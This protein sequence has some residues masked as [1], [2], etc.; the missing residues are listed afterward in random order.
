[1]ITPRAAAAA[2]SPCRVCAAVELAERDVPA[3][4]Q[5]EEQGHRRVVRR[6][7]RLR[8]HAT[9]EL[10]VKRLDHVGGPDRLPLRLRESDER[11]EL[12]APSVA[13]S[14][15]CTAVSIA[16]RTQAWISSPANW[17]RDR[18]ATPTS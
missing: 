5:T 14:S 8:F 17:A 9:A 18:A 2:V 10:T 13:A 3:G 7:R 15:S 11:Q 1:M 4:D 6:Q 16:R 12:V